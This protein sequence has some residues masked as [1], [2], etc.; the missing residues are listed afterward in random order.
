MR[1][2]V[3]TNIVFSAI[4]NTHG[5]IGDLLMN[6]DNV[7]DFYSCNFLNPDNLDKKNP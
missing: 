1:I 3:D 5:K 6:S 4:I 2:V 7:F